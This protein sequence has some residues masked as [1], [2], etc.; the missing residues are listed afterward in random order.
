[1]NSVTM[2]TTKAMMDVQIARQT[3]AGLAQQ[4]CPEIFVT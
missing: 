3:M 4:V 2:E 1:M